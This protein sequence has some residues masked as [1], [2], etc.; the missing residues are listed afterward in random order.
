MLIFT[1]DSNAVMEKGPYLNVTRSSGRKLKIDRTSRAVF[2]DCH[3]KGELKG[4]KSGEKA[5]Q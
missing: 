3:A 4:F 1:V 5:G 2:V